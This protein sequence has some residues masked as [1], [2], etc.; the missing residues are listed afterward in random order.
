MDAGSIDV[1]ADPRDFCFEQGNPLGQ[2]FLGIRI[3][4]FP[5]QLAG[6]IAFGAGQVVFHPNDRFGPLGL[7]VNTLRR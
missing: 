6:R 1:R 7:A 2:F 3:K 5:G 4:N